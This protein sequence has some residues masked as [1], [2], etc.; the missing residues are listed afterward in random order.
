ML[1]EYI[2]ISL[3]NALRKDVLRSPL[4]C[5]VRPS[6]VFESASGSEA[7]G[8]LLVSRMFSKALLR[9]SSRF[10]LCFFGGFGAASGEAEEEARSVSVV[11]MS[12]KEDIFWRV[13]HEAQ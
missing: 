10:V 7:A 8:L 9:A 12:V 13:G 1:R 2:R 4:H 3:I 11:R 5:T 6:L